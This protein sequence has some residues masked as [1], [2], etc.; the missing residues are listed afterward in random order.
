M[1]LY[2]RVAGSI[3]KQANYW[4]RGLYVKKPVQNSGTTYIG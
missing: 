3:P 1:D 2:A 4:K